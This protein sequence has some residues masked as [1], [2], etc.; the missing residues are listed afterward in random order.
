[1]KR[2]FKQVQLLLSIFTIFAFGMSACQTP[3]DTFILHGHRGCRGLMPE[4][5]IPAFIK[6]V[7]IGVNTL[8]L[9]VAVSAEG[10]LIVSHEPW[11]SEVI[12]LDPDGNELSTDSAMR[13]NIHQMTYDE[14]ASFDCG[15]VQNPRFPEQQNEKTIKPRLLDALIA[16]DAY[17]KKNNL[18]LLAWNIEIKSRP[19]WD[20]VYTPGPLEFVRIIDAFIEENNLSKRCLVQSFDFRVLRELKKLNTSYPIAVLIDNKKSPEVNLR[21]L[22]FTPQIYSPNYRL[23][24]KDLVDWCHEKNMEVHPWTVNEVIAMDQMIRYGV[25]GLITDYPDRFQKSFKK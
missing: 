3:S 1:M 2:F 22:G 19:E 23:V 14:I 5:T 7:E 10:E 24:S 15:S 4:N 6:A 20:N 21:E 17:C 16:V 11:F 13:Y 18:P 8:E 12:C 9:D 25:D